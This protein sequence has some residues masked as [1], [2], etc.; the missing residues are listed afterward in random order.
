MKKTILVFLTVLGMTLFASSMAHA[1][2]KGAD[3]EQCDKEMMAMMEEHHKLRAEK[4]DITLQTIK[5]I[6]ENAKDKVVAGKAEALEK[7]F[8][9]L[10]AKEAEMHEKAK[11]DMVGRHK[12]CGWRYKGE[13]MGSQEPDG[14]KDA[15]A[16]P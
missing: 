2:K 11:K 1:D 16:K 15:P 3:K 7:R 6:E 10:V 5:L 4:Q 14:M 8:E 12:K 9:A 13:H